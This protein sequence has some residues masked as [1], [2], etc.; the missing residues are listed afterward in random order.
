MAIAMAALNDAADL[1][2]IDPARVS[3]LGHSQAG[4]WAWNLALH[5]PTYFATVEILAANAQATWLRLRMMGLR[6]TLVVIWNDTRD[7]IAKFDAARTDA[8]VVK[9]FGS[10][11]FDQTTGLG[12]NPPPDLLA[13]LAESLT[14][15]RRDLYPPRVSIQSTSIEPTYNRADWVLMD[16][17]T[18]GGPVTHMLASRGNEIIRMYSNTF[19]VDA[20]CKNNRIDV[21]TDNTASLRLFL[22]DQMIDFAHP[23]IVSVNGRE[24]RRVVHPS[25]QTM[26]IDQLFLGRG[27]RY[28]TATI[29]IDLEPATAPATAPSTE[30]TATTTESPTTR[31][32]D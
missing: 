5:Q 18:E 30:P 21:T 29:D 7:P 9:R 25:L 15:T 17:P 2:D 6:N 3:L 1:T 19:S 27:W 20:T 32:Q 4:L 13:H 31:A 16:Q 22:N 14:L 26:L 23:I 11:V 8:E 12:H 28:F 24:F 10:A